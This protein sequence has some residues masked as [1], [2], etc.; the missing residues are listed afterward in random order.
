VDSS[1]AILIFV[2]FVV[3]AALGGI[4]S[5]QQRQKRLAELRALAERLG[6]QFALAENYDYDVQFSQ[7]S[8]FGRGDNRYAYNTLTGNLKVGDQLWPVRM[9]DYH[10]E[11]TSSNGKQTSTHHHHF[12]YFL[13]KLPYPALPDLRIRRER[14]FD[15]IAGVMGFDDINFESAEFSRRFHVKS[16]DKRFAYDVVC[17]AMM[18]FL[19]ANDPPALEIDGGWCYINTG[20]DTWSPEEFQLY[21]DWARN[22]FELWPRHLVAT[23][24]SR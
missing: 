3:L 13:V 7:F 4:Y 14:F 18:E 6:W 17:P 1:F 19:L 8:E 24:A 15:T 11:T 12:S 23:L 2:V 22:F 5:Y 9:G 20:R 21:L 16:S 10:F